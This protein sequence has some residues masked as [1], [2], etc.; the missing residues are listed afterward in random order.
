MQNRA[1]RVFYKS[2][3]LQKGE[4]GL[5][6]HYCCETGHWK[7]ACPVLKNKQRRVQVQAQARLT[8]FGSSLPI[9]SAV[10]I[11]DVSCKDDLAADSLMSYLPFITDGHVSL[12]G[13]DD[14]PVR[15]LRNMVAVDS[16]ILQSV[17]PFSEMSYM[18]EY[19]LIRG[20]GMTTVSVPYIQLDLVQ[21][22]VVLGIRPALPVDG[23]CDLG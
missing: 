13:G 12:P 3:P 6:C 14:V 18:G 11:T 5:S 22:E 1:S 20:F 21:E 7:V 16:C 19:V 23:S 17:L 10:R 2:P 15:I 8:V 4:P 9:S